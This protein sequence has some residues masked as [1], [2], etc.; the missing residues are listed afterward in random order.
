MFCVS[1]LDET[2]RKRAGWGV[3]VQLAFLTCLIC[4]FIKV[5][6]HLNIRGLQNGNEDKAA[7]GT[8]FE[9]HSK[10]PSLAIP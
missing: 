7:S 5:N 10:Q 9:L 1:N 4:F 2:P 6:G 8:Y 3:M